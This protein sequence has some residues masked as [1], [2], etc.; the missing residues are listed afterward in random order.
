MKIWFTGD[1]SKK[2]PGPVSVWKK[3]K[4]AEAEG[5]GLRLS[6]EDVQKLIREREIAS[7]SAW[8]K[9][10]EALDLFDFGP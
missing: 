8:R 7:H 9:E 10:I 4:A 3:L 1:T 5:S 6:S 2:E